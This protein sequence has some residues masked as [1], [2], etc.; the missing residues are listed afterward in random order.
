MDLNLSF[1][2]LN[3]SGGI[4]KHN[5]LIPWERSTGGD[6]KTE[7]LKILIFPI[8]FQLFTFCSLGVSN[9]KYAHPIQLCLKISP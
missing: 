2:R 8:D 4:F 7:R 9:S 1:E 5:A 3:Y 6:R